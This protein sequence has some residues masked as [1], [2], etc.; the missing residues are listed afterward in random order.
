M[1]LKLATKGLQNLKYMKKKKS[2]KEEKR[3][4]KITI[5]LYHISISWSGIYLTKLHILEDT[6]RFD[7][8]YMLFKGRRH[9]WQKVGKSLR[10]YIGIIVID[11]TTNLNKKYCYIKSR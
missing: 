5:L 4:E 7:K 6:L 9:K 10:V 11:T 2:I 1:R 8:H 3:W